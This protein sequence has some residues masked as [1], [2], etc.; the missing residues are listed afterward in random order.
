MSCRP[1]RSVLRWRVDQSMLFTKPILCFA[2]QTIGSSSRQQRRYSQGCP[3][4]GTGQPHLALSSARPVCKSSTKTL[5]LVCCVI[6]NLLCILVNIRKIVVAFGAT[7]I[8]LNAIGQE[9]DQKGW[10]KLIS[11]I[12]IGTP[13]SQVVTESGKN[14]VLIR[15]CIQYCRP[16]KTDYYYIRKIQECANLPYPPLLGVRC[17][18]EYKASVDIILEATNRFGEKYT[19]SSTCDWRGNEYAL[20]ATCGKSSARYR[21]DTTN[22]RPPSPR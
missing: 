9:I 7:A 21:E 8:S 14:Q 19:E 15:E 20:T 4:S 1:T 2:P 5:I 17:S 18:S 13:I 11:E 22:G 3:I 16:V 6:M 10:E 12:P